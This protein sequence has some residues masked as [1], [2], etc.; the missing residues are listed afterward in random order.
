MDTV[1]LRTFLEVR[2]TRHFGKAAEN[3]CITPAAVS[4]RIKQLEES[5]GAVLFLRTRNNIQLSK[6]GERLVPHAETMLLALARA[7]QEVAFGDSDSRQL[8]IAVRNGLW[9]D[10]LQQKLHGLI[11]SEPELILHLVSLGTDEIVQKLLAGTLDIAILY[12]PPNVP[13]LE[14]ITIGELKLCLYSSGKLNNA[15]LTEADNYIY[16]DWGGGFS[17]F[18]AQHFG[19]HALPVLRT[20]LEEV[21]KR[22]LKEHGGACYLPYGQ[23]SALAEDGLS[24]VRGAAVFSRPINIAY[25]SA[26]P[27][28]ELIE[29]VA[30]QFS[31]LRT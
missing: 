20:N 2:K 25:H 29:A 26:S 15:Q 16:L 13:E 3:L 30:Q 14:I 28:R 31:G 21:A 22:Y 9:S 17:R 5:L 1:L 23:R 4:A 10:S 6:E 24:P 7:R 18:H 11:R 27:Q 12:A 8:V 19:D